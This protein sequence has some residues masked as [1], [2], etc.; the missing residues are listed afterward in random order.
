MDLRRLEVLVAVAES[1]TLA[2]AARRLGMT[3]PG[4]SQALKALEGEAGFLIARK[5]GRK[6]ELTPA[7]RRLA[8]DAATALH[9]VAVSI[10]ASR[11]ISEGKA[12]LIRIAF[13][14]S[15]LAGAGARTLKALRAQAPSLAFELFDMPT[16]D[17][18]AALLDGRIDAGFLHPPVEAD[19]DV[20]PLFQD[21]LLAVLPADH[22]AAGLE[23]VPL[24]LL[25]DTPLILFPRARGPVLYDR[26]IAACE[27]A[28]FAPKLAESVLPWGAAMSLAAIGLGFAF[29]PKS[30]ADAPPHGAVA[31]PL[32][33]AALSVPHALA[34][35]RRRRT[36][37][38][39]QLLAL[40]RA[41]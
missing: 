3:Q 31:K 28:D 23:Q 6:L 13:T 21:P 37:A 19:L 2:D 9:C 24:A 22:P 33:D 29:V 7:A 41:G 1:A 14:T 32:S 27:G 12:G 17:Q 40:A 38:E 39:T 36:E 16:D 8:A 18:V 25:R 34:L 5:N 11:A 35:P 10:E 15:T 26:I 30:L 4:V 20:F